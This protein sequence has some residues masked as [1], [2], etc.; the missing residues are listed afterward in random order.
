MEKR[1]EETACISIYLFFSSFQTQHTRV[2]SVQQNVKQSAIALRFLKISY[3]EIMFNSRTFRKVSKNA[4][5]TTITVIVVLYLTVNSLLLSRYNNQ[6]PILLL[7]KQY[8]D[9][10]SQVGIDGKFYTKLLPYNVNPVT[11]EVLQQEPSA[12]WSPVGGG[13]L[14]RR[15]AILRERRGGALGTPVVV[16]GALSQ[17][18]IVYLRR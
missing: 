8:W 13:G 15:T 7:D 14:F 4:G 2:S 11:E 6:R 10:F 17:P 16:H 5:K 3:A 1:K 12:W 9:A 18:E